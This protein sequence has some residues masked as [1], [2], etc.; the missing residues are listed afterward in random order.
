[1]GDRRVFAGFQGWEGGGGGGLNAWLL[2]AVTN[3]NCARVFSRALQC[4]RLWKPSL[5]YDVSGLLMQTSVE[6]SAHA[7]EGSGFGY[8]P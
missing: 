1:M 2:I 8:T 7:A 4:I 6:V 5:L 3:V